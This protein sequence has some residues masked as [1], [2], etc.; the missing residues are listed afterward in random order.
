MLSFH[1]NKKFY[2]VDRD[3]AKIS[4]FSKNIKNPV[5]S[6]NE[7]NQ[8]IKSILLPKLKKLFKVLIFMFTQKNI[9]HIFLRVFTSVKVHADMGRNFNVIPFK[10]LLIPLYVPKKIFIQFF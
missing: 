9:L 2:I 1:N 10:Q 7:W 8:V 5:R 4:A 6:I 3:D